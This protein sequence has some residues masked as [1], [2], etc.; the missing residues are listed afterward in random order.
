MEVQVIPRYIGDGWIIVV[1]C[2]E[3]D[4]KWLLYFQGP[5]N[6]SLFYFI[7]RQFKGEVK[8]FSKF[9]LQFYA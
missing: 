7:S 8:V 3:F 4:V 6:K 9:L 2:N 5:S 1:Y